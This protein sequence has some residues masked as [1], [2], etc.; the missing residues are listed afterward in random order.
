VIL[1]PVRLMW[2]DTG[3][4]AVFGKRSRTILSANSLA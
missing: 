4:E 1:Q 3:K 2:K